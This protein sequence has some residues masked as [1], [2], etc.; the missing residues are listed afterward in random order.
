MKN[1]VL[2]KGAEQ[3]L[4][5]IWEYIASDNIDA[6]DQWVE[7][8]FA[9]FGR[10]ALNPGIG[11]GRKDLTPYPILFWPLGAYLIL[12]RVRDSKVE[13]VAVTQGARDIPVFVHQ[14]FS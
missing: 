13:I 3:D 12:Y 6:A 9:S 8:L 4:N 10:I 14:R 2:G 5:E 1:Y 7:K 11:H